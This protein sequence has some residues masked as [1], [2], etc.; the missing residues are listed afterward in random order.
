M[1][2]AVGPEVEGHVPPPCNSLNHVLNR[3]VGEP[4]EGVAQ[5]EGK[6]C[7]CLLD[8]GSQVTT[9]SQGYY[10]RN[11][12]HIPLHD[13]GDLLRVEA[14]NGSPIPYL[15]YIEV[16]VSFLGAL[17]VQDG[18]VISSLV[19]IVADTAYNKSVPMCVGVNV[20]RECVRKGKELVGPNFPETTPEGV[21]AAWQ[22]V[23][24]A[25]AGPRLVKY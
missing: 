9:L 17:P 22:L 6:L 4:N 15:G 19:L 5:I 2:R 7:K 21:S 13:V 3:L 14:A 8:T 11:F 20:L 10:Q 23:Y 25:M 18:F 12:S 1:G 24:A 16:D